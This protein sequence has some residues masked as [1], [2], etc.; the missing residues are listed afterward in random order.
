M[1]TVRKSE[2]E[3]NPAQNNCQLRFS[4]AYVPPRAN[5]TANARS[6]AANVSV[7]KPGADDAVELPTQST[8]R[9]GRS[10]S[11]SAGTAHTRKASDNYYED[12]DPRFA[13]EPE[14]TPEARHLTQHAH[15]IPS[16]L[17]PGHPHAAT[18]GRQVSHN[19]SDREPSDL[20]EDLPDGARSPASDMTS[21][22]QRGINP[23][24]RPGSTDDHGRVDTVHRRPLQ[25][26]SGV[27]IGPGP[28]YEVPVR[29]AAENGLPRSQR[30]EMGQAF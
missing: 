17:M 22:S 21:I 18:S 9:K 13:P 30:I 12:V 14:S 8:L 19:M 6:A 16:L 29:G 10:G 24:W 20:Y 23:N 5:W 25:E 26:Q 4:R 27:A 3:S 1:P 15:A 28:G 2:F 11:N 7:P